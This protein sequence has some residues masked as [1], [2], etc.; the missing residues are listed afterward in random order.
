MD[1]KERIYETEKR[2]LSEYAVKS[3]EAAKRLVAEEACPFRTDFMRDRDRIIHSKAFRRLMHKMQ[4]FI[5]PEGDHYRT[6]LTH[7]L[8]VSQV[9]RT[10]ARGL[11]LN[12][13]LTEAIALG[14]DL[15]H[16]PFGH[17]GEKALNRLCPGGFRHNEQ[18][19]RVVSV[20]E[21]LNLTLVVQDGIVNHTDK[22]AQTK[23]GQ[24]VRIADRIA[25][26][27]HDI[28]DAFR[29]K[30][31]SEG[32]I[33]KECGEILGKSH[34]GRI[35]SMVGAVISHGA[36]DG[37]DM[38]KPYGDATEKLRDFMF[39]KVYNNSAAKSEE[40]KVQNMLEYF[41]KRFTK[42]PGALPEEYR[43]GAERDGVER[44]AADYIAGMTD[45]YAL[46]LFE[47]SF[48]PKVW[49]YK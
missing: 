22:I 36:R 4:V 27:N 26:I 44:A 3:K 28:D 14:H 19:L 15:G 2:F 47:E 18:S 48:V 46:A 9:A 21:K 40:E 10:I 1:I 30:I 33:P 29:A 5:A 49:Q 20:L 11:A 12:E 31:L 32:D 6:R 35:S 45:R 17:S 8:E 42:N 37:I 16:T 41:F 25:Y 43:A 39:L 13:D 24:V 23:E 7:T 38:D 34:S